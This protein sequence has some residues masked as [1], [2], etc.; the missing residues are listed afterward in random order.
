MTSLA[1]SRLQWLFQ[2]QALERKQGRARKS[3]QTC[4]C[5]RLWGGG[6]CCCLPGCC[7]HPTVPAEPCLHP[8]IRQGCPHGDED[9]ERVPSGSCGHPGWGGELRATPGA[10]GD[11]PLGHLHKTR[12]GPQRSLSGTSKC[13]PETPRDTNGMTSETFK[14]PQETIRT[15]SYTQRPPGTLKDLAGTGK[16]GQAGDG[17]TGDAPSLQGPST[18]W[19]AAKRLDATVTGARAGGGEQL[20]MSQDPLPTPQPC[21]RHP[22]QLF[23]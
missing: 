19:W 2:G 4:G 9:S 20:P 17:V 18:Q 5:P 21:R 10:L 15:S 12:G 6:G 14:D 16:G 3:H 7:L 8:E 23:L 1:W 22:H 11:T 13:S